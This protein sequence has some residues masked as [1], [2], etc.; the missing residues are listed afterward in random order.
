[1]VYVFLFLTTVSIGGAILACAVFGQT[2]APKCLV[3]ATVLIIL[4]AVNFAMACMSESA[5][6]RYEYLLQKKLN[7]ENEIEKFLIEH[8]EFKENEK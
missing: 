2:E 7:I 4:A 3:M 1:M 6:D 8:P 5:E